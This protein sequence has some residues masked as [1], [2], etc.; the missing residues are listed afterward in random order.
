MNHF[1]KRLLKIIS[2]VFLPFYS[3]Q[4]NGDPHYCNLYFSEEA[5]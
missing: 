3:E 2:F 4:M 1:G 5:C